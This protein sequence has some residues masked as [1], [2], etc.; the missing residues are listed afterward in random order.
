M[1]SNTIATFWAVSLLL[2]LTPGADWAYV[3]SAGLR[4]RSVLPALGG[5]LAGQVAATG[6][7]TAGVAGVVARTPSMMALITLAGLST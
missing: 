7:V 3:I 5:L 2:A 6:V 4:Y 1:Q